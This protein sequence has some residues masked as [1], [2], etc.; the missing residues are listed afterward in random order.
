MTREWAD[1]RPAS[2]TINVRC[3]EE[4]CEWEGCIGVTQSYGLVEW[5]SDRCPDCG[6]PIEEAW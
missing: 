1:D 5:E 2:W 4:D 6:E 3:V